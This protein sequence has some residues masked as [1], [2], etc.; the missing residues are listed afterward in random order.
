MMIVKCLRIHI[1]FK[2][3]IVIWQRNKVKRICL[4]H[5]KSLLFYNLPL[6]YAFIILNIH[7]SGTEAFQIQSDILKVKFFH[8]FDDG[9][10]VFHKLVKICFVDFDSSKLVHET[11]DGRCKSQDSEAMFHRCGFCRAVHNQRAYHME[12]GWPCMAWKVW[13]AVESPA[14]AAI[15]RMSL[16]VSPQSIKG[17]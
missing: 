9:F 12:A 5:D 16:L 4:F 8:G 1:G 13:P 6:V 17:L 14:L 7:T 10:T 3:I 15:R 2:S 11:G